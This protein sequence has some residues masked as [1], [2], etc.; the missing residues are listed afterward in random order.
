[1]TN[2]QTTPTIHRT[3]GTEEDGTPHIAV[4]TQLSDG[5]Q[6]GLRVVQDGAEPVTEER[7]SQAE[8]WVRGR[9]GKLGAK[10]LLSQKGGAA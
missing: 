9:L 3:P 7:L 5:S 4:W 6:I 10:A 2:E 1:M 8:N